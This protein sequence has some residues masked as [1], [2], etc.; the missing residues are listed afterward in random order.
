MKLIFNLLLVAYL[1]LNAL[2]VAP[3]PSD[4]ILLSESFEERLSAIFADVGFTY[5]YFSQNVLIGTMAVSTAE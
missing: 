3:W 5:D 4:E 1:A 2:Y